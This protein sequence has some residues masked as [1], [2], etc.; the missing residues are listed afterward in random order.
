M[1]R[2]M[3]AYWPASRCRLT[4]APSSCC[5]S[6]TCTTPTPKKPRIPPTRY[7]SE[8]DVR[9]LDDAAKVYRCR[10]ETR[11]ESLQLRGLEIHLRRWGPA[12]SRH[13]APLYC[14][15]GWMDTGDTFQFLADE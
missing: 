4:P 7:S 1:G 11:H 15:H 9:Q 13:S 10:R 14:L 6:M 3:A 2:I 12:P 5:T 8:V